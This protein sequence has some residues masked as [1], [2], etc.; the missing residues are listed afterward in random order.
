MCKVQGEGKVTVQLSEV[1]FLLEISVR[2][3]MTA[4]LAI[5]VEMVSVGTA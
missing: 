3:R 1:G 4:E 5:Q 2:E